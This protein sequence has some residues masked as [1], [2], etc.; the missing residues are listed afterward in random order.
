[1]SAE[2]AM[3]TGSFEERLRARGLR[4]PA[5]DLGPLAELVAG[6]DDAAE[7]VRSPLPVSAEPAILL[8]LPREI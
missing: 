2:A 7:A 5:E 3:E 8:V 1:M 6:L 4:I